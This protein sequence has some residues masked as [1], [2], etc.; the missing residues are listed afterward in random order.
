MGKYLGWQ[1]ASSDPHNVGDAMGRVALAWADIAAGGDPAR[2]AELLD[3][4]WPNV[5][6]LSCFPTGVLRVRAH[7][8]AG[9]AAEA[10][11]ARADLEVAPTRPRRTP[12]PLHTP[13]RSSPTAMNG[14]GGS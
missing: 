13:K 10:A 1:A 11:V 3:R 4:A 14:A 2:T 7:L 12:T 6:Y 9:N 5:S 8:A